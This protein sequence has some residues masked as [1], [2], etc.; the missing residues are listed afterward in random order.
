MRKVLLLLFTIL[1]L[2]SFGQCVDPGWGDPFYSFDT[3]SID[4]ECF[5]HRDTT[6]TVNMWQIGRPEKSVFT[7]AYSGSRVIATDTVNNYRP[8]DTSYFIIAHRVGSA[9]TSWHWTAIHGYYNV[10]T[11]VSTDFGTIE[12]SPDN[13]HTWI[14]LI[15]DTSGFTYWYPLGSTSKPV[16]WGHSS[17]WQNFDCRLD[18]SV[19]PYTLN[20]DDTVKYRLSF[21]TDNTDTPNEGLMFDDI[22]IF[23]T[24]EDVPIVS[25]T[26]HIIS[27]YPNP[28]TNN[29]RI[30][31]P[32]N[33]SH[34]TLRILNYTGSLVKEIAHY[35]GTEIDVSLLPSG[36]YVLK[37]ADEQWTDA[38]MFRVQH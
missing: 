4:Y 13:G 22:G 21:I 11:D 19:T 25:S 9:T 1:P 34:K 10:H 16:L 31:S 12:F 24:A 23:D 3:H 38:V 15:N 5:F 6:D 32:S 30:Q 7:A 29:I 2:L 14:D 26:N 35:T 27:L 17:G 20:W 36:M 33:T 37:Y 28:A 8:N 18:F